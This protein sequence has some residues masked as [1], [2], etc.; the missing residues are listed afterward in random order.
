MLLCRQEKQIQ[1][2]AQCGHLQTLAV[3]HTTSLLQLYFMGPCHHEPP[4]ISW[5]PEGL[6]VV[7]VVLTWKCTQA[8]SAFYL[9]IDVC[10][11]THNLPTGPLKHGP[12]ADEKLPFRMLAAPPPPPPAGPPPARILPFPLPQLLSGIAPLGGWDANEHWHLHVITELQD[13]LTRRPLIFN[14]R[15]SR[16][17][18]FSLSFYFPN[19]EPGEPRGSQNWV[20]RETSKRS[21]SLGPC[22]LSISL[23]HLQRLPREVLRCFIP[24]Y[25]RH[26]LWL[27]GSLSR[28]FYL[29]THKLLFL[30]LFSK[31]PSTFFNKF[32]L[33]DGLLFLFTLSSSPLFSICHLISNF[34]QKNKNTPICLS[35][36]ICV[37]I[38][39]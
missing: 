4:T 30:P 35:V 34:L 7:L 33:I 37:S 17:T 23:W 14:Q 8:F 16:R 5:P 36:Y 13:S 9:L 32:Q 19:A 24:L 1:W 12:S 3:R 10:Q 6:R 20:V 38:Y 21:L 11:E 25:I 31:S 22:S 29:G 39:I 18:D 26:L 28:I 27:L 15:G 2:Q